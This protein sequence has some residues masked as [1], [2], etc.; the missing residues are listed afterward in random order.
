MTQDPSE[1]CLAAI[2]TSFA[3]MEDGKVV[4]AETSFSIAQR[5]ARSLPP[6]FAEIFTLL[7][8]CHMSLLEYRCRRPKVAKKLQKSA[9]TRLDLNS[10]RV[11]T[12]A[13]HDAMA[14]VLMSLG[15]N[16]RA[17]PFCEQAI[18]RTLTIDDPL[19]LASR[20]EAT[21]RC[22]NSMGLKEYAASPARIGLQIFRDSPNDP[23][24]PGCLT[25]LGN[26]LY[27]T[28]PEEAEILYREAAEIHLSKGFLASATVPW[29]NLGVLCSR[30]ARH[31][32]SLEFHRKA[33]EIQEQDSATKS[34]RVG[35][36]LNNLADCHRRMGDFD[37]AH[38]R[39]D[40]SIE[41]LKLDPLEGTSRLAAA[42]S[43]RGLIFRDQ[44]RDME[45]VT[46]LQH[47]CTERGNA[48]TPNFE[49][50]IDDLQEQIAANNRLGRLKEASLATET[51]AE[52]TSAKNEITPMDC[53]DI[54]PN[55]NP[56]GYVL[57]EIVHRNRGGLRYGKLDVRQLGPILLSAAKSLDTS[58]SLKLLAIKEST[59]LIFHSEN[60]E[61]AF[62]ALHPILAVTPIC[63]G[64]K[65]AIR[66]GMETRHMILPG[67]AN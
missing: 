16:R 24:L 45:A 20:L 28:L 10:T 39:L 51:L 42:Y 3:A 25:T 29:M 8:Q 54:A 31:A 65:V 7:V 60:A 53:K 14:K 62:I 21:A 34:S 4:T 22:Y 48:P 41:M 44:G 55:P 13:F 57:I 59:T 15:E 36:L 19:E 26:A 6:N 18:Q 46:W 67:S 58:S 40:Q 17:L 9:M 1:N 43:T 64:A 23:R 49:Q 61:V 11:E 37:E 35:L 52:V 50:F 33:L 27:S 5:W 38:M 30:Q 56:K 2:R 47:A 12:V 32:E 63:R 66:Q